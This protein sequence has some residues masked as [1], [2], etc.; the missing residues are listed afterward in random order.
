MAEL[1]VVIV[2][3]QVVQIGLQVWDLWPR[4]GSEDL[5]VASPVGFEAYE[6][7]EL[8]EARKR[9]RRGRG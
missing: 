6:A 2:V 4:D 7:E 3:L 5:E 1:L 9:G 8:Y